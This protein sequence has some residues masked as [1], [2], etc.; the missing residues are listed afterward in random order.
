MNLIVISAYFFFI[1][2]CL[3]SF[4]CRIQGILPLFIS[5]QNFKNFSLLFCFFHYCYYLCFW[6]CW[7]C[8]DCLFLKLLHCWW[9]HGYRHLGL[10][11]RCLLCCL[12]IL[13]L[14][15]LLLF[16]LLHRYLS[17]FENEFHLYIKPV[18][19]MWKAWWS[20]SSATGSLNIW[21]RQFWILLPRPFMSSTTETRRH[22]NLFQLVM[23]KIDN[24][25]NK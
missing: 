12:I 1:Y 15:S 20:I 11:C 2:H 16:D 17:M 7:R 14:H 9:F 21:I 10:Y 25:F 18:T 23:I 3:I 6:A 8:V 5:S 19:P 4:F 22:L 24:I 13:L